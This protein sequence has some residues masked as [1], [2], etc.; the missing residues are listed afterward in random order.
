MAL[1]AIFGGTGF[2]GRRVVRQLSRDGHRVRIVARDPGPAE[3]P[4]GEVPVQA[5]ILRPESLPPALEGTDG[6][7][8]AVS[9]YLPDRNTGF[10]D[11]HVDGAARLAGAAREAGLTRFVHV[12]GIGAEADSAD[13]FI[14][15]RGDGE[16]AVRAACP[17][18]TIVRPSVMVGPDD[19]IRGT[20]RALT[21]LQPLFPLF[22]RGETRLQPV[23]RDDVAAA[24]AR[25][26]L[27]ENPAPLY[28]FGGPECLSYADLVR[29]IA[30]A[31]G[32]RVWPVPLPFP[33]WQ[34]G[35]A[36]A[37]RLPRAPLTRSQVALM[38]RDN[39]AAP[40]LPGL[41]D[42][43]IDPTGIIGNTPP[44]E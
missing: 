16:A 4:S 39:V 32:H 25:L 27:M 37:E 29:R 1:F 40:D 21:R 36:L 6:A 17:F 20:I 14:R 15:S 35:A 38:R 5:D 23:H 33:V 42:L 10:R 41:A 3:A 31:A 24:I 28:E 19:A 2:L 22:G 34:L 8:N 7:V 13:P 44:T 12:S 26:L 18:A 30:G 9:L 43:G 11:V